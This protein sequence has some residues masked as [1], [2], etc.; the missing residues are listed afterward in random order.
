MRRTVEDIL[1]CGLLNKYQQI[2]SQLENIK[3]IIIEH[4]LMMI[5]YEPYR[6]K[7]DHRGI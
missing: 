1:S 7:Y 5:M 2:T 6:T 3:T 4:L